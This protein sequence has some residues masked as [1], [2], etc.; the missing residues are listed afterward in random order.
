MPITNKLTSQLDLPVWEWMRFA[1]VSTTSLS[2]LSTAPD[3]SDRYLYYFAPNTLYRYDTWGDSWQQMS[4]F[5]APITALALKYVKNQGFRGQVLSV[6]SSTSL[7]IPSTGGKN[8]I[9][10]KI[11]IVSGTGV[12]QE[13]TITAVADEVTHDQGLVTTVT[14]NV[15]TDTLKKWKGN[16]WEGYGARVVYGTGFSQFREVLYND[17][18]SLTV[19]DANYEGRN[20]S[21]TPYA[22]T[23]PYGTL[24]ITAG[25]QA[26]YNI[27][28]QVIT[29]DSPWTVTPDITSRFMI[30]SGGIWWISSNSVSPFF[31]FYYFDLLSDRWIQKLS[32]AGIFAGAIGT[33]FDIIVASSDA[34]SSLVSSSISTATSMSFTDSTFNISGSD[35]I[36]LNVNITSGSGV[37][38]TRRIISNVSSSFIIADKWSVQPSS[39][40]QYTITG[41]DNLYFVGNGLARTLKYNVE[42]SLWSSGQI[43]DDGIALQMALVRSNNV[44]QSFGV[45]SATRATGSITGINP[46]PTASGSGYTPGDILTITTGGNLGRIFV[47]ATNFTGSVVSASLYTLGNSYTVGT[48]RATSGGTGTGCTIEITSIGTGSVITTTINHDIQLGET[49]TFVGDS[50]SAW[51]GNYTISG[52][53]AAANIVEAVTASA[54][55]ASAV[56]L[57]PLATT[58]LV[59]VTKNWMPGE[60]AGKLLGVQSNGL[61]GTVTWRRIVG[62]SSNTISFAAGVA[63]TNGNSRY[64]I[65]DLDALGMDLSYYQDNQVPYGYVTSATISS[66][67]DNTKRWFPLYWNNNKMI[68]TD[69]TGNSVET[70]ITS[71]TTSSLN[72]G[73]TVAVGQGTNTIAYSEDNGLSW[74]GLGISVFATQGNGVV[75]NG[76]RFVAVGTSTNGVAWSNDGITWNATALGAGTFTTQGNGVAWNG[77]RFVAVGQGTN[78][79]IW[80]NDGANWNAIAAGATTFTTQGNG[81]AWNGTRWVAV[82]QGTNTI[83]SSIDGAIWTGQGT[84][85]FGTAGNG[86]TWNGTRFVAVGQGTNTIASST[87]GITWTGQGTSIFSAVGSGVAWNGSTFVA[88]GSGTNTIA[89]SSD[90]LSWTGIGTSIFTTAGTGV[91]WN[92]TRFVAVGS[93]TNTI[94]TSTDGIAW[95]GSGAT[96]FT[97]AGR[98][99][100][101]TSPF[102]SVTPNIGMVPNNL[103]RYRIYDTTGTVN[104]AGINSLTDNNKRWKVNQFAGKRVLITSGTGIANEVIVQSNTATQLLFLSSMTIAPD[105]T[106]TYTILGRPAISTGI[107]AKYNWGST[108][109]RNRGRLIISPRGGGSHTFDIYDLRTN[110]WTFGDFILAQGETLTTG[111]MYAYDGGDN[112]YFQRDATGRLMR[113]NFVKKVIEPFA[114]IPY[115]MST[116]ILSNRMEIVKTADNL[117]YIYVMR[118]TSNEMWRTLIY[119]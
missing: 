37:G 4:T 61:T 74:I 42:S 110:R 36:N 106:S 72:I 2:A 56:P 58:L 44:G 47:E 34:T 46:V 108:D 102:G 29:V 30:M 54:T 14:Q 91:S 75:W 20:W 66:I 67:T 23:A 109:A 117:K 48:G 15:L 32:P 6:P 79:V 17:S 9:G 10:I 8:A 88:V 22:T 81:I 71:N 77:T 12:G 80:S 38:Q 98:G 3:G 55:T 43:T 68:M 45:T 85:I 111:T 57:L 104:F 78:S 82:G 94:A 93:G 86:A 115:G 83:A 59:D 95:T 63:P 64:F 25:T 5:G 112:I 1:P 33:D 65:Q 105:T 107:T 100:A 101:S 113:Y 41:D 51:N 99:V 92:G 53:G 97:T 50:G 76:T 27:V 11:K 26:I 87:D 19:F 69:N 39:G 73:R 118:H 70:I 24:N 114:T 103:T 96:I 7:Q 84:T 28:S 89:Y 60:H 35:F 31:N 21:T 119:T 116:A 16:Q 62:N 52:L 18:T 13:R 40:D 49:L 90:G